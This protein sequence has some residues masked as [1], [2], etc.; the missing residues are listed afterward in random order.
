MGFVHVA[1]FPAPPFPPG[2]PALNS[3]TPLLKQANGPPDRWVVGQ[4]D[5]LPIVGLHF[6]ERNWAAWPGESS[7]DLIKRS[8][9]NLFYEI[10][11][12]L[13]GRNSREA[14][15]FAMHFLE[16]RRRDARTPVPANPQRYF[17][18]NIGD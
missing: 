8:Q 18:L 1:R 6:L 3:G 5:P 14:M 13:F 4:F 16:R 7:S 9:F 10:G 12:R 15:D 11:L 17:R 2:T